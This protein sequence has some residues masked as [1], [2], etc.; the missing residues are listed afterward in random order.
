MSESID[1][2]APVYL[3]DGRVLYGAAAANWRIAQAGGFNVFS[4]QLVQIGLTMGYQ[5]AVFDF[6]QYSSNLPK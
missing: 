1:F 4:A 3:P 6:Q 5:K 2:Y